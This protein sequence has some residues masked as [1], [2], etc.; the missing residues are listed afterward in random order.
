MSKVDSYL[1]KSVEAA[2]LAVF[3]ILFGLM[4]FASIVRFWSYG[5][6]EKLYLVP[7]FHFSY[8][9]ADFNADYL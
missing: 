3:R 5:W 1:N 9:A 7:D 6:I 4:M 2:P 8:Y